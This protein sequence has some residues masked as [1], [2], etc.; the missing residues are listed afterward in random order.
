[1]YCIAYSNSNVYLRNIPKSH[2]H[3]LKTSWGS[4]S[5]PHWK[6]AQ[7]LSRSISV[8]F[9]GYYTKTPQHFQTDRR[10]CLAETIH[11]SKHRSATQRVKP[12]FH[13]SYDFITVIKIVNRYDTV[14]VATLPIIT[15]NKTPLSAVST[16]CLRL[17][18]F[19][20]WGYDCRRYECGEG[21][22]G[23]TVLM[24]AEVTCSKVEVLTLQSLKWQLIRGTIRP[25]IYFPPICR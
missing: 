1:M 21:V 5:D 23:I 16:A 18:T 8:G 6:G 4:A 20:T 19:R 10:P 17:N 22:P 7:P 14:S 15:S 13:D 25:T 11:F 3:R 24:S 9:T 2:L 12:S